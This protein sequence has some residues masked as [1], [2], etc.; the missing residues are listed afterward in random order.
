M[1]FYLSIAHR[2][3][4]YKANIKP[5]IEYC[6]AVWCDTSNSNINKINKLQRW[7]CKLI[8]SQEYNGLEESLKRIDILSFDQFLFLNKAKIMYKVYNNLAPSHLQ[9]SFHMIDVNL[10][11]TASNLRSV[12]KNNYI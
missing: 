12:A 8:L 9:E 2:N 4:F 7:A 5:H 6:S 10:N 3:S 1:R 11:N